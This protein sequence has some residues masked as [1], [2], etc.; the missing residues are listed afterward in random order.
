MALDGWEAGDIHPRPDGSE[1]GTES[2]SSQ[3]L[4]SKQELSLPA[5]LQSPSS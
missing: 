1:E 3:T 2:Q 4:A 5:A